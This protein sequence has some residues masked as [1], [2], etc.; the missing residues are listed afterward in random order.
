MDPYLENKNFAPV[1]GSYIIVRNWVVYHTFITDKGL[2]KLDYD[3]RELML[4]E[5]FCRVYE[6]GSV[7]GFVTVR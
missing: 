5:G 2:Y 3:P 4:S 1:Q 7:Q 6:A